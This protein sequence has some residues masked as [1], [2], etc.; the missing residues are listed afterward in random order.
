MLNAFD[1][2]GFPDFLQGERI[3]NWVCWGR[4]KGGNGEWY[5]QRGRYVFHA[6]LVSLINFGSILKR[7]TFQANFFFVVLFFT[8]YC[9]LI[10]STTIL[11]CGSFASLNYIPYLESELFLVAI[12]VL[13]IIFQ[14]CLFLLPCFYLL[15]IHF[16]D[17]DDGL[18]TRS[19]T[20][21]G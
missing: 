15:F 20:S 13:F 8:S 11:D 3:Y 2:E 4:D 17:G 14:S 5:L 1:F 10:L 9:C 21:H 19:V 16:L 12:V 6:V 7:Q 18:F